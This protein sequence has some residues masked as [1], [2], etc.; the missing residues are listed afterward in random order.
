MLADP[1]LGGG[2]GL[3]I[4]SLAEGVNGGARD[5]A[6]EVWA[7]GLRDFLKTRVGTLAAKLRHEQAPQYF[8]ARDAENFVLARPE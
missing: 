3:F 8:R 7:D 1:A 5:R 2:H 6:G 4:Y